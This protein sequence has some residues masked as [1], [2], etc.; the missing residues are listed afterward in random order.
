M[1]PTGTSTETSRRYIIAAQGG[2][3]NE[4]GRGQR[5]GGGENLERRFRSLNKN[6]EEEAV[7][8]KH[9]QKVKRETESFDLST[10]SC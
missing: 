5:E 2:Y 10:L 1:L 4:K 9:L 8:R 7:G 6:G 3:C